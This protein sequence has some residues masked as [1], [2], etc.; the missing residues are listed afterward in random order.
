MR[1]CHPQFVPLVPDH[2]QQQAKVP[3]SFNPTPSSHSQLEMSSPVT[4]NMSLDSR[5][6]STGRGSDLG[7]RESDHNNHDDY[8]D[9]NRADGLS[10]DDL[11]D[12]DIPFDGGEYLNGNQSPLRLAE[13]SNAGSHDQPEDFDPDK[14]QACNIN[15]T[16]H[17]IINGGSY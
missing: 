9:H 2:V 5:S 13:P 3:T 12:L 6:Q 17:P 16:Y 8:N 4:D 14:P 7:H 15:R 11:N 10:G 1:S